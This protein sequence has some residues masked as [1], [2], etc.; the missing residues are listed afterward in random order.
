MQA[1]AEDI[2]RAQQMKIA[3]WLDP[4]SSIPKGWKKL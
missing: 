2:S 3:G 1:R 4:G